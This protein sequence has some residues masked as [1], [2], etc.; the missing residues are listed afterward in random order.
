METPQQS[1][2]TK[3]SNTEV[4]VWK[5]RK[6]VVVAYE[7]LQ[8]MQYGHISALNTTHAGELFITVDVG[9]KHVV[10]PPSELI[11]LEP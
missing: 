2:Y 11:W 1:M 4:A 7:A 6:G 9:T 8:H 5:L 10:L 3:F